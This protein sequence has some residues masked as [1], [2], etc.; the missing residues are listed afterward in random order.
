MSA[1]YPLFDRESGR[2]Y[3]VYGTSRE[4]EPTITTTA[5]TMTQSEYEAMKN[6]EV[7][8]G[9]IEDKR[10]KVKHCPVRGQSC[11][12]DACAL[13][14]EGE[15]HYIKPGS[16]ENVRDTYGLHCPLSK[17][18]GMCR[19]SCMLRRGKGCGLFQG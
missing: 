8:P 4:Y 16:G 9:R 1:K 12:G 15:C 17:N 3:R 13:F 6:S 14:F 7:V 19:N 10:P 5:G 2:F 18:F 11:I